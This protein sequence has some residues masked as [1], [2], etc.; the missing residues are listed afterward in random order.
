MSQ[1]NRCARQGYTNCDVNITD[2]R[3]EYYMHIRDSYDVLVTSTTIINVFPCDLR[4]F[5][6]MADLILENILCLPA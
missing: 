4:L 1:A 5:G 2:A 6:T 3:T